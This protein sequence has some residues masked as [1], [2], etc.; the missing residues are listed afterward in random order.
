MRGHR[1]HVG[2]GAAIRRGA[3]VGALALA[4]AWAVLDPALSAD[5]AAVQLAQASQSNSEYLKSN[6]DGNYWKGNS[7]YTKRPDGNEVWT[8]PDNSTTVKDNHTGKTEY[9]DPKGVLRRRT[10]TST[11]D[12]ATYNTDEHWDSDGDWVVVT[13]T[14]YPDGHWE[15]LIL[16]HAQGPDGAITRG[17]SNI[18][19]LETPGS[20]TVFGPGGT[21]VSTTQTSSLVDTTTQSIASLQSQLKMM[22]ANAPD[23]AKREKELED[24]QNRLSDY[25]LKIKKQHEALNAPK[26]DTPPTKTTPSNTPPPTGPD[27]KTRTSVDQSG[28]TLHY[29]DNPPGYYPEVANCSTPWREVV[30]GSDGPP[31]DASSPGVMPGFGV[32]GFGFGFGGGSF[33]GGSD[34]GPS[35]R[36][37]ASRRTRRP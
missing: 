35:D 3:L 26:T 11:N 10:E 17:W 36:G 23:R 32:G 18:F 30:S 12:F 21:V 9:R 1:A 5:R 29:C 37:S 14:I 16:V 2:A 22:P 8:F 19:N 33:G 20:S 15:S 13:E 28:P 24:A 34:D 25:Q 7:T 6:P 4:C 31:P 27:N